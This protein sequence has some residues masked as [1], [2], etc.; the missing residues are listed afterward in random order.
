MVG[1]ICFFYRGAVL[2]PILI[3]RI[4][5][6]D[7]LAAGRPFYSG[8]PKN[9]KTFFLTILVANHR[10]TGV[11]LECGGDM[12][13]IDESA[14]T[15]SSAQGGTRCLQRVAKLRAFAADICACGE[16]AISCATFPRPT[17]PG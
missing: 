3:S 7:I 8:T 13:R 6:I 1:L 2:V 5:K 12:P 14:A 4:P 15:P 9:V 11:G 17:A 16:L 10:S